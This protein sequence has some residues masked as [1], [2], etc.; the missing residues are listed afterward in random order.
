MGVKGGLAVAQER[1]LGRNEI[2]DGQVQGIPVLGQGHALA[3]KLRGN[4]GRDQHH[5]DEWRA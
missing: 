2:L 5:F 4:H 1:S 3:M